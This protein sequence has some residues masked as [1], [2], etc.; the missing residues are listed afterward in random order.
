MGGS[1]KEGKTYTRNVIYPEIFDNLLKKK[2][3]F[4]LKNSRSSYQDE[5][6]NLSFHLFFEM[7]FEVLTSLFSLFLANF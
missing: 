5:K 1:L 3:L 7:N 6:N 2:I 4:W